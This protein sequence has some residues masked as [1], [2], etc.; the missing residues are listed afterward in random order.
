M[1]T[2]MLESTNQG[3]KGSL[4]IT[5]GVHIHHMDRLYR[6]TQKLYCSLYKASR[7]GVFYL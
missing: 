6:Y 7:N 5:S 2:S 3:R 4:H 1:H